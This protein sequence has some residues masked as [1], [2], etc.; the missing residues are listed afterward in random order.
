MFRAYDFKDNTENKG[1]VLFLVPPYFLSWWLLTHSL[2]NWWLRFERFW[3][4][5]KIQN[6]VVFWI[7]IY[8]NA[9]YRF[10]NI[11]VLKKNGVVLKHNYGFR[12]IWIS[13][14]G[15]ENAKSILFHLWWRKNRHPL[16][17]KTC[18][19]QLQNEFN[20]TT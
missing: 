17:Y 15:D 12:I 6:L 5:F 1:F 3:K 18:F 8:N 9:W 14:F 19:L 2:S 20:N 16:H 10:S 7:N 11:T 13:K 4:V